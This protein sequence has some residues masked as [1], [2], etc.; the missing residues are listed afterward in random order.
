M[1][2]RNGVREKWGRRNLGASP[3]QHGARSRPAHCIPPTDPSPSE[4]SR[5][6]LLGPLRRY[7]LP[8]TTHVLHLKSLYSCTPQNIRGFRKPSLYRI[9]LHP[10]IHGAGP[11]TSTNPVTLLLL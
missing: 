2:S 1:K 9:D 6:Q 5:C 10:S 7:L 4:R 11:A 8:L 3:Q